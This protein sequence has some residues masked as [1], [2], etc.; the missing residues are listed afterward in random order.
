VRADPE[1][2]G[3]LSGSATRRKLMARGSSPGEQRRPNAPDRR[4]CD[5]EGVL[6]KTFGRELAAQ[7]SQWYDLVRRSLRCVPGSSKN[8]S[9]PARVVNLRER[10]RLCKRKQG[11]LRTICG[12]Y[13]ITA[14]SQ[15]TKKDAPR[16]CRRRKKFIKSGMTSRDCARG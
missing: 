8:M 7:R 14:S 4:T 12:W 15:S 9:A 11:R 3:A 10:G 2:R 6:A 1:A 16:L 13:K 5:A